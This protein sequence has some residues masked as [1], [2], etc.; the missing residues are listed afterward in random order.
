MHYSRDFIDADFTGDAHYRRIIC[1]RRYRRVDIALVGLSGMATLFPLYIFAS[2]DTA[3]LVKKPRLFELSRAPPR[4]PAM[5]GEWRWFQ[6]YDTT[7]L[8]RH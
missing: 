4:Q 5:T 2:V 6:A 8:S 1:R 3:R 7:Y